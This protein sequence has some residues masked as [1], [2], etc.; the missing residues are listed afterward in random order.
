[1]GFSRVEAVALLDALFEER[2]L[3]HGAAPEV[4][5]QL[6]DEPLRWLLDQLPAG[7]RTLETGCGYSTVLL[8]AVAEHHTVV[9]PA[10]EEHERVRSWCSAHGVT[11][12]HVR[13]VAE[14]SQRWLPTAASN[15]GLGDLDC[16]L[17]DG[18][19]AFPVPSIDWYYTAEALRVGG[20]CIVDDVAIRAC[21]ELASFLDSEEGRWATAGRLPNT[22]AFRK[23][24]H[25]VLENQSW[26]LQPWNTLTLTSPSRLAK[27]RARV[28]PRNRLRGL[29]TKAERQ[30]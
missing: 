4:N 10:T 28:R 9:A 17:I 6:A 25:S 8:A 1:M 5:W 2:P 20:L 11:T 22:V 15:A 19:H 30:K 26:R 13:F 29:I 7:A 16:V 23:L 27:L 12:T 21:G 24:S 14:A 18:D 3:F